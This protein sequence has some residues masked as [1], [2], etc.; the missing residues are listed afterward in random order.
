VTVGRLPSGCGSSSSLSADVILGVAR[1]HAATTA[2][3]SDAAGKEALCRYILR[4]PI[5]AE[6]VQ[7]VADDLV[8]LVLKRPFG[9][10]TSSG[11]VTTEWK[12]RFL[13]SVLL[14]GGA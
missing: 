2:S 12:V 3:A 1:L 14:A 4:P 10:G 11:H 6:R 8:R 7:L 5:A 13:L 9:D